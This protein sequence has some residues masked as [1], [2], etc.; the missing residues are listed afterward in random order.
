MYVN[1]AGAID[2]SA[3]FALVRAAM[4]TGNSYQFNNAPNSR[5]VARKKFFFEKKNQKTSASWRREVRDC[6]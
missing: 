6:R 1:R 4:L 3:V 5:A 2:P